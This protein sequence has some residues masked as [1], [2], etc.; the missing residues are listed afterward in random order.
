MKLLVKGICD[1]GLKTVHI[2]DQIIKTFEDLE[3]FLLSNPGYSN[4]LKNKI[5]NQ[6][7]QTEFINSEIELI[8]SSAGR[9]FKPKDDLQKNLTSQILHVQNI[10]RGGKGGFGSLLK[11][12][13]P[14]KK[15]TNN[16]DSCRDLSGRRIRHVNQEKMLRDWQQKKQEE[17]KFIQS[18]NNPDEEENVKNYIDSENRKDVHKLNKKYLIES[19]ETVNSVSES[20]KFLLKKKKREKDGNIESNEKIEYT[21]NNINNIKKAKEDKSKIEERIIIKKIDYIPKH[22]VT[23]PDL[24]LLVKNSPDEI[25]KEK[26][27][28]E[29]FTIDYY[30][31]KFIK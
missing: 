1:K 12:Q 29:I 11:G 24:E 4:Y 9:N 5:N 31:N 19:T 21:E 28:N 22:K 25:D 15:R 7:K 30:G 3:I 10:V 6:E 27:E 14:T 13:P 2:D 16:F 17:E 26:L 18:F 20:V 23:L 8:F